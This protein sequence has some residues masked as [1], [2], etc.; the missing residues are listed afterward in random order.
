MREQ[1]VARIENAT[2]P[3][4]RHVREAL[5]SGIR[6]SPPPGPAAGWAFGIVL[7]MMR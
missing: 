5:P 4:W 3:F 2:A 1:L 7:A 6:N